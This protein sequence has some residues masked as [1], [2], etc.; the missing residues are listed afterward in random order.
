MAPLGLLALLAFMVPSVAGG[1]P[2]LA[3]GTTWYAYVG[4]G[5]PGPSP[6]SCPLSTVP[7]DQCTL[8]EALA[9]AG[10]GDIVALATPGASG[11]YVGNWTIGT[12]ATS[13]GAP[14]TIEPAAGVSSPVLDGNLGNAAGCT[15]PSC[16][17]PVLTVGTIARTDVVY[18]ENV[19]HVVITGLTAGGLTIEDGFN[20]TPT[21]HG[22]GT[23]D[24]SGV[25]TLGGA[26]DNNWG[27]VLTVTDTNFDD[28]TANFGGAIINASGDAIGSGS[29]TV[30]DCTFSGNRAVTGDGG[31]INTSGGGDGAAGVLTVTGSTFSANSASGTTVAKGDGGAIDNAD[32]YGSNGAFSITGS[33]FI[34]NTA[35]VNG[36]A[37]DSGDNGGI[38]GTS[39]SP[40]SV[41]TSTFM[42]NSAD[43]G[44]TKS[45]DGGAIDNADVGGNGNLTVTGSTF[46]ANTA[47]AKGPA[48]TLTTPPTAGP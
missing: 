31:A 19:V 47:I 26:I 43:A 40:S 37:I 10:A 36:G 44:G 8:T 39:A 13:P 21:Q 46:T 23:G 9:A 11:H 45:G 14:V 32:E 18:V 30:I 29:V 35:S 27:G 48:P 4:G 15:T 16:A 7:A 12:P 3:T 41:A 38:G 33:T 5:A 24:G 20:T 28:N 17:G 25:F 42:D 6:A 2:A 34:D 1:A 22:V